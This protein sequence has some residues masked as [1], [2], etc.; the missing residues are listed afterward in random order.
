MQV[1]SREPAKGEKNMNRL[2]DSYF[3]DRPVESVLPGSFLIASAALKDS[4]FEQAVVFVLQHNE[5]GTFGVVLNRPV[6]AQLASTWREATGLNFENRS[7]VNGGP[8]GGPV[9]ALHSQKSI[10]EVEILDG[11]CLSIDSQAFKELAEKSDLPY[12]IVL[13]IAGWQ[14]NQLADE[15]DRGLWYPLKA[16]PNHIF[17]EPA[18][19]WPAF[20]RNFG[21]LQLQSIV[22][23]KLIP[24][25]PFLN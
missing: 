10:A 16:D 19:M 22:D 6:D 9:L 3:P 11:I 13:G 12:R 5:L 20:M 15:M 24:S 18:S 14:P 7:V 2:I 21:Y 25:D 17:D 4:S 1:R 23:E 8:I